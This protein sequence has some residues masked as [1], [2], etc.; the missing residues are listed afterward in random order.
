MA[1]SSKK[2]KTFF[3]KGQKNKRTQKSFESSFITEYF[4]PVSPRPLGIFEHA[5]SHMLNPLL[6]ETVM[7]ETAQ[8][9]QKTASPEEINRCG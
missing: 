6:H 3:K 5:K 7:S 1:E 4:L 2:I 9:S 8:P